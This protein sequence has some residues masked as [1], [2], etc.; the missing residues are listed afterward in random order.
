MK[1]DAPLSPFD[2][3]DAGGEPGSRASQDLV[4]RFY[5]VAVGGKRRP[6]GRR[7][8]ASVARRRLLVL[9]LGSN[10]RL[11]APVKTESRVSSGETQ[12]VGAE[13]AA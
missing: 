13:G 9:R 2:R 10:N 5:H 11:K 1:H 6:E 4:S 3:I 8:W 7:T 12:H